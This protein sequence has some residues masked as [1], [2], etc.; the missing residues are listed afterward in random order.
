MV[1]CRPVGLLSVASGCVINLIVWPF[2]VRSQ[3]GKPDKP[4]STA[5]YLPEVRYLPRSDR[6]R[7]SRAA[8]DSGQP[9]LSDQADIAHRVSDMIGSSVGERNGREDIKEEC[10]GY[11]V[12]GKAV[13]TACLLETRPRPYMRRREVLSPREDI[14]N[15]AFSTHCE[16]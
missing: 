2:P 16:P 3:R 14:P 9:T 13:A 1:L 8:D 4:L 7:A 6:R 12:F 10:R 11:H 5:A 15:R